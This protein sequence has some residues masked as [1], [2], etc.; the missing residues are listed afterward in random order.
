MNSSKGCRWISA[1]PWTSMDTICLTMVFITNFRPISAPA[2][3]APP[4]RPSALT[5]VCRADSH[6]FSLHSPISI[7]WAF[8]P[9]LKMS[10]QSCY[11][12]HQWPWPAA[13]LFWSQLA[14]ALLD[15]GEASGRFSPK[16]PLQPPCYQKISTQ[17]NRTAQKSIPYKTSAHKL[18]NLCFEGLQGCFH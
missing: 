16:P 15:R 11:H 10:S 14:L 8:F 4:P 7:A 18:L 13:G 17:L 1:L 3:G 2:P 5:L 12:C 9:F 6:I